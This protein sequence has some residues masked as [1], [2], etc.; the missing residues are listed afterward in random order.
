MLVVILGALAVAVKECANASQQASISHREGHHPAVLARQAVRACG[1]AAVGVLLE[2]ELGGP[3][4]TQERC[5]NGINA[6]GD[7]S[8]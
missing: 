4:L 7:D 3:L 1:G 5:M 8:K 6:S 2:T